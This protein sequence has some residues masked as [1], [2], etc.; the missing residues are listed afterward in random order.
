MSNKTVEELR[1]QTDAARAHLTLRLQGMVQHLER[2]DALGE[3]TSRA[4]LSQ[5]LALW[6][7]EA[8]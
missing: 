6:L 1:G 4:V 2:S 3:R 7:P 8:R 5:L